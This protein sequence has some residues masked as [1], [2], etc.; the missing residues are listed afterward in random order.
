MLRHTTHCFLALDEQLGKRMV[1]IE[2]LIHTAVVYSY[3]ISIQ[4][5]DDDYTTLSMKG[6]TRVNIQF[7]V[8]LQQPASFLMCAQFPGT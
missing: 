6:R 8:A 7:S 3:L 2:T 4:N 1:L 5:H